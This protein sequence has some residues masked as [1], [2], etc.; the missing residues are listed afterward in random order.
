[1]PAIAAP[2]LPAPSKATS[3]SAARQ[4]GPAAHAAKPW[5][6]NPWIDV[7]VVA[8]AFWPLLVLAL[9]MGGTSVTRTVSFWQIYFFSTPHRWI[10]LV[11]VFFDPERFRPQARL[12]LGLAV[13]SVLLCGGAYF[14]W[15]MPGIYVL[16]AVDFIWNAWHFASQHAGILRIYGRLAHGDKSGKGTVEKLLMRTFLLYVLLRLA[17]LTLPV[18]ARFGAHLA[19]LQWLSLQLVHL[20]YVAFLIPLAL[21]GREVWQ[22]R[23]N[24]VGRIIYL[25]SVAGIYG[26][27][28]WAVHQYHYTATDHQ[29]A[30][31]M[32]LAMAVSVFHATEYLAIVSWA[33]TSKC[34]PQGVLA[35]LAPR[36]AFTLVVFMSILTLSA[37]LIDTWFANLWLM[38][39]LAVSFLH[40]AY[41]GIIWK[42]RKK[43]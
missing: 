11:L 12:F 34:N 16:L 20:D 39:N 6:F 37:A 9:L 2:V 28:L 40:Y 33:A 38:I 8:N 31:V 15:G 1:M 18:E 10:T 35:Y 5:L 43:A 24:A 4:A 14:V 13:G 26:L 19:W 29:A 30:L 27:L 36:W 25:L 21:V 42:A 3:V 23:P 17:S 7:L 22:F 41:D 32:A